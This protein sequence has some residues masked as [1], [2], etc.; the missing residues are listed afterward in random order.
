M[1]IRAKVAAAA[2]AALMR[3]NTG[4]T[5]V[6]K[7]LPARISRTTAT[8]ALALRTDESTQAA[9]RLVR[10]LRSAPVLVGS[11]VLT[12]NELYILEGQPQWRRVWSVSSADSV[13]F[14]YSAV[15]PSFGS[16]VI[17]N[18]AR[19][20]S[21]RYLV[22]WSERAVSRAQAITGEHPGIEVRFLDQDAAEEFTSIVDE[23]VVYEPVDRGKATLVFYL[24]PGSFPHRW[25][26]ADRH[27]ISNRLQDVE[28]L[29]KQAKR[30]P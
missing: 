20:V 1:P 14:E 8:N 25:I 11:Q 28:Q 12:D 5:A 2:T 19:G 7:A 30:M 29:W 22:P 4:S 15:G 9:E 23:L 27:S 10:L 6:R 18:L 17:E 21:Y 13:E 24:Y 26:T 16:V 3:A